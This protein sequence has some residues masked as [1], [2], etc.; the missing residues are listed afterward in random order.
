ML[1]VLVRQSAARLVRY[2]IMPDGL[3]A[4]PGT[5]FTVAA[6][7]TVTHR[8]RTMGALPTNCEC[9]SLSLAARR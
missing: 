1:S 3:N 8:S 6:Q 2:T 9:A 5:V 4:H 7:I